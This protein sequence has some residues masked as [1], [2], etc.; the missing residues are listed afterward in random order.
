[1][2]E[3]LGSDGVLAQALDEGAEKVNENVITTIPE[4]FRSVLHPLEME[5]TEIQEAVSNKVKVAASFLMPPSIIHNAL[6]VVYDQC[7]P[8]QAKE[9]VVRLQKWWIQERLSRRV[10]ACLPNRELDVAIVDGR[11]TTVIF[12]HVLTFPLSSIPF[13]I[14]VADRRHVWYRPEGY[15]SHP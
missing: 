10:E 7:A 5:K 4:L 11:S 2:L 3:G 12:T 1:V 14:G 8:L 9:L 13:D 15:P 6:H